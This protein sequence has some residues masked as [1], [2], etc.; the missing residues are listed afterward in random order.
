M[1]MLF[2]AVG[3]ALGSVVRYLMQSLIGRYAGSSF[4]Y[5]TMIVNIAGSFAMGLLIGWIGRTIPEHA[6]E[7]HLFVA[8]GIL[9]GFTTFSTFSLEAINLMEEGRWLAMGMYIASSVVISLLGLL[10]GLRL[11]RSIA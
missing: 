4:P 1:N 7:I 9:G 8:V 5:G 2:I 10:T 11:M 3:G 6:K